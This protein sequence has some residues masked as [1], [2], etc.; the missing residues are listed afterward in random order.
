M[1]RI[2]VYI[3]AGGH[4]SRFEG[5]KARAAVRGQPLIS[6][7]ARELAP[8]ASSLMVVCRNESQYQDLGLAAL[9]DRFSDCGPL[10]GLQTALE[11]R[12]HGWLLLASCDRLG[13]QPSWIEQLWSSR[14][15]PARVVAF[16]GKRW[17]TLPALYH[18]DL[19]A[20]VSARVARGALSLWRLIA[21]SPGRALPLPEGWNSSAHVNR[22][23][24][25]A[26][27]SLLL[28]EAERL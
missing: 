25:L 7:V 11:D 28:P 4:G 2:A 15:S 8:M 23:E 20:E 24:D 10:G 22:R 18:T 13:L 17:E 3:L 26:T 14:A 9:A 6:W 21:A 5:D 27:V 12:G 19:L 16:R 1:E